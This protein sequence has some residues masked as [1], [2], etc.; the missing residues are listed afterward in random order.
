MFFTWNSCFEKD[1][2]YIFINLTLSKKSAVRILDLEQNTDSNYLNGKFSIIFIL[3][4]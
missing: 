2:A 1:L 3:F 4:Y